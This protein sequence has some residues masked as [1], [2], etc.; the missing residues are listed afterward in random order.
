LLTQ[1]ALQRGW[2]ARVGQPG[3]GGPHLASHRDALEAQIAAAIAAARHNVGRAELALP[4]TTNAGAPQRMREK[5]RRLAARAAASA[6]LR[7]CAQVRRRAADHSPQ[8]PLDRVGLHAG[9]GVP[10]LHTG[11]RDVRRQLMTLSALAVYPCSAID[12]RRAG[13]ALPRA[14]DIAGLCTPC[15]RVRALAMRCP[16]DA[17][18]CA[19]QARCFA[20]CNKP[21]ALARNQAPAHHTTNATRATH[22]VADARMCCVRF[23]MREEDPAHT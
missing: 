2:A 15:R 17:R 10:G 5:T 6:Q 1:G 3:M 9:Q 4:A 13:G 19:L 22:T 20:A 21:Q 16:N 23:E 8:Q 11:G 14:P 12:R 18:R 7:A